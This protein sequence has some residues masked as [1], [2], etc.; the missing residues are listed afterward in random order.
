VRPIAA[1]AGWQPRL[2]M[3]LVAFIVVMLA[4]SLLAAVLEAQGLASQRTVPGE[5]ERMIG[6]ALMAWLAAVPFLVARTK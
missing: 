2:T 6:Y 1:L 5:I 4:E 3:A